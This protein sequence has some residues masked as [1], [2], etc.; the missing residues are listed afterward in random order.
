MID[1]GREVGEGQDGQVSARVTDIGTL[2]A[3]IRAQR[4]YPPLTR[5]TVS[6]QAM[7]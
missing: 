7:R 5:I 3:H 1:T 4:E 6:A 2:R